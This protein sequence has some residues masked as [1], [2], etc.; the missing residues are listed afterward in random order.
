MAPLNPPPP[1]PS[2]HT[3]HTMGGE[4]KSR[5]RRDAA[6]PVVCPR[7]RQS[8]G[9]HREGSGARPGSMRTLVS[10][11]TLNPF[12]RKNGG[13]WRV[14]GVPGANWGGG[15][16]SRKQGRPLAPSPDLTP[17]LLV[18]CAMGFEAAGKSRGGPRLFYDLAKNKTKT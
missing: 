15:E 18:A 14:L 10:G 13:G 8:R 11:D 4:E 17:F 9:A 2:L 5:R 6:P 16:L 12:G 7:R 1:P 3:S